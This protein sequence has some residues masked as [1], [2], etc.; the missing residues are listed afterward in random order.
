MHA[1]SQP[2][3]STHRPHHG[4]PQ[5]AWRELRHRQLHAAPLRLQIRSLN[6]AQQFIQ[7]ARLKQL[8]Q[9][10]V[11]AGSVQQAGNARDQRLCIDGNQRAA[12]CAQPNGLTHL[13]GLQAW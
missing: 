6:F 5:G 1:P 3:F 8:R 10:G 7:G 11:H 2:N 4:L 13:G 9:L 12:L